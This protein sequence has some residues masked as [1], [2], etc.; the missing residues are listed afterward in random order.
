MMFDTARAIIYLPMRRLWPTIA[1][2]RAEIEHRGTIF[3]W[4]KNSTIIYR[5]DILKTSFTGSS[6]AA[7]VLGVFMAAQADITLTQVRTTESMKDGKAD[8]TPK[9]E[10]STLWIGSD[11]M[12]MDNETESILLKASKDSIYLIDNK[13]KSYTGISLSKIAEAA[14]QSQEIPAGMPEMMANMMKMEVTIEPTTETKTINGWNCTKYLQTMKMMGTS[15]TSELWAS[16]D[17][18]VDAAM[19][20]KFFSSFYLKSQKMK[21][22]AAQMQ[23]EYGKIKGF[24][25]YSVSTMSVMGKE[26]RT[27]SEMKGL[28]EATAPAGTYD[29]PAKFKQKQWE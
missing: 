13:K 27:T 29:V 19:V 17:V 28:K 20:T 2:F 14:G 23:K 6:I 9:S 18:K 24:I 21:S 8:G 1:C 11:R 5:E 22:L 12:R 26:S 7:L 4:K 15:S 3:S 25:V 16:T 10:T